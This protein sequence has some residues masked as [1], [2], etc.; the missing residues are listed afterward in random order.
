MNWRLGLRRISATWWSFCGVMA[1]GLTI[2][3]S[4]DHA[5]E[6]GMAYASGYGVVV[7]GFLLGLIVLA[8]K[9]TCWIIEGFFS[10]KT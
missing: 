10:A 2:I 3:L 9:V 6:Q 7:G 1:V 8:H 5:R 4:L